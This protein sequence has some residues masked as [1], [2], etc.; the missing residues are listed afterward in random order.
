[1][2][3]L[4]EH[5]LLVILVAAGAATFAWLLAMRRREGEAMKRDLSARVDAIKRMT[6]A[7]EGV[8]LATSF[9]VASTRAGRLRISKWSSK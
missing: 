4:L 8:Q 7:V 2:Q 3:W 5:F 6:D 1:M 9:F